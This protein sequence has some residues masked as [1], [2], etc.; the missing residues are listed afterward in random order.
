MEQ[1]TLLS[2]I[3]TDTLKG[4]SSQPKYL[5]SKY[6]YD[7]A[8]SVIFQDIMKMQ[9][10]YLTDCEFDIFSNQKNEITESFLQGGTTFDLIEL[11]PGDGMKTKILLQHMVK[12]SV[13][14]RYIPFD[15]SQKSNIELVKSLQS[16]LPA[17]NVNAKTG[18]YFQ[19][20]N[21]ISSL[22]PLPLIQPARLEV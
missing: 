10:Y 22:R 19:V 15:I 20:A 18:D 8:G 11:G 4:L 5:L 9:E 7:D 12:Q 16:E 21:I 2:D 13:D 1:Q 17:L 6:F 14:S 3:A